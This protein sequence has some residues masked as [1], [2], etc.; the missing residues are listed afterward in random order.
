M[1]DVLDPFW[2]SL[3]LLLPLSHALESLGDAEPQKGF[4]FQ[5]RPAMRPLFSSRSEA[6]ILLSLMGRKDAAADLY[7]GHWQQAGWDFAGSGVA[8]GQ[9]VR[10]EISLSAEATVGVVMGISLFSDIV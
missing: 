1:V 4:F 6:E 8:I 3:D 7:Q 5:M 9:P 2:E 10:E